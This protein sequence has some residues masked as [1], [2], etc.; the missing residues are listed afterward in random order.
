MSSRPTIASISG[1]RRRTT[2]RGVPITARANSMFWYAVLEGSR[3][4]SWNTMPMSRRRAGTRQEGIRER[5]LP[6]TCTVPL[7]GAVSLS[8]IR[9]RVDLPDPEAPTRNTNSPRANS[10]SRFSTAGFCPRMYVL[11]TSSKRITSACRVW[12]S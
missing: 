1:T 9:I 7:V 10:M 6:A 11:V 4:K 5:S 8:T 3:R 12:G 2:L